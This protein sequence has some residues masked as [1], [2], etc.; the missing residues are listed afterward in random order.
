MEFQ[1]YSHRNA[2]TIL[3]NDPEYFESWNEIKEVLNNL[4]DSRLIECFITHFSQTKTKSISKAVNKLLKEDFSNRGW[5]TESAIFQ[6]STY[7]NTS[8]WRLDMAKMPISIEV[9]F[10]HASAIAWNLLKP[11]L[12]SELNHVEKAIQTKMGIIICATQGLKSAG[13]FDN[14][15]G[16]Y[17]KFLLHLRPMM[18]QLSVPL[19]IIGLEAPK[20][21]VISEKKIGSNKIGEILMNE[22][23][24]NLTNNI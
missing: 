5:T 20:T 17:E 7:Q 10:N 16:T 4:S 11:V 23:V 2:L 18:N 22:D 8:Y 13:N 24:E 19:L 14:A 3:E 6:E 12:A 1:I 21:F 15:I 9:A